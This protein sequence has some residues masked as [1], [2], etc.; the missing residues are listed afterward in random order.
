MPRTVDAHEGE[1]LDALVWRV[2]GR[3]SEAVAE[4]LAVNPGLA[5]HSRALPA[6]TKV[7]IPDQAMAP[8]AA[9]LLQIWDA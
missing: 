8:A 2:T 1:A 5:A 9:T 6:D 7:L 4:V 3:G